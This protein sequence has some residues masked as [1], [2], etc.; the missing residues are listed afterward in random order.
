MYLLKIASIRFCSEFSFS[1]GNQK[2]AQGTWQVSSSFFQLNSSFIF[3]VIEKKYACEEISKNSFV[4]WMGIEGVYIKGR[5]RGCQF[6]ITC[7]KSTEVVTQ[8]RDKSGIL[9]VF[10]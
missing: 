2:P 5:E 8:R 7:Y 6:K 10:R 3:P 4:V 1:I 9:L